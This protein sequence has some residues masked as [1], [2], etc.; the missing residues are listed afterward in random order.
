MNFY[1]AT[2]SQAIDQLA[3]SEGTTGLL[4]MKR[5]AFFAFE[6]LEKQ[7]PKARK[8]CIVTGSGN[9]GGDGFALAQILALAGFEVNIFMTTSPEMLKG[10]ALTC[11]QEALALGLNL[12]GFD[13]TKLANADL[14]VDAIF[15]TG[16]NKIVT[17]HYANIIEQMNV[18]QLPILALDIPS[19]L[20]ADTGAV[21][22]IAIQAQLTCCFISRK[23][24]L[25]SFQ[26]PECAGKIQFSRLFLSE[27]LTESFKPIAQNHPLKHWLNA[28]PKFK[29]SSHKGS[30]GTCCLIGGNHNMMGAIQLAG[31]ACL[32][33]GAGLVKIVTQREHCLPITQ[34]LPELMAYESS[35]L[36]SI[37]L[38]SRALA[39]G[40]GLGQDAWAIDCLQRI[41]TLPHPKVMDAD[42]LNLLA[43]QQ[44][45][46][47][48]AKR[49]WI[50]TPH[51]AEAARL[52]SMTTAQV[53]Q[54]RVAAITKLHEIYGGVVVLKGNGTLIFDGEHL[55]ICTAGNAGMAVGGM[56]DVL[57]GAL[58]SLLGQGMPLFEAACLGVALHAQAG[59]VL[60]NQMGQAGVTPSDL[61]LTLSQL[62]SYA[63]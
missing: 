10:D 60:A 41:L 53:Q 6:S 26:G 17:G 37:L 29:P 46:I 2:Q 44:V 27:A 4:L 31:L 18:S 43:T 1:N 16:L 24:G 9:N 15:G 36:K 56:G 28:L 30:R 55:E 11:Y 20:N 23:L 7:W 32:K 35:E 49:N 45:D 22:G 59:D 13:A 54:D 42:A 63:G 8:I 61:A 48:Q 52:L 3:I 21:L 50:L 38:S 40:P 51:P 5:A 39:I 57:T 58:V 14:L 62:L 25:Y 34:A 19:G 47:A 12:Q 33:S